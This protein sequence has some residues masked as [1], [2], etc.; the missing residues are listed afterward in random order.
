MKTVR[1]NCGNTLYFFVIACHSV[2]NIL[3]VAL[4]WSSLQGKD[5]LTVEGQI[6][7]CEMDR[8]VFQLIDYSIDQQLII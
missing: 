2:G 8:L 3:H 6:E 4:I 5:D 7:D 1:T